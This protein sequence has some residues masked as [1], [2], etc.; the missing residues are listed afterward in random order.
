MIFLA[1]EHI[2][3]WYLPINEITPE[4]RNDYFHFLNPEEK[5][6]YAAFHFDKD[7]LRYLLTRVM[8]RHVLAGYLAIPARELT[9]TTNAF[10]RPAPIPAQNPTHIDINLSHSADFIICGLVGDGRI[11]VDIE[12]YAIQR[13]ADVANAFFAPV[14]V[15]Q[16]TKTSKSLWNKRFIEFWTLKESYIKALGKGMAIPL[17]SFYFQ[18]DSG[19]IEFVDLENTEDNASWC[20]LMLEAPNS[21]II[22][23]STSFKHQD[24]STPVLQIKPVELPGNPFIEH[25]YRFNLYGRS[26]PKIAAPVTV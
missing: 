15:A 8:V 7:R 12:S 24:N 25:A 21:N 14:E 20:F 13:T 2:D 10:G 26:A 18:L 16:L 19:Q 5:V 17:D 23:I 1:K 6:Q 22:S 3:L 4:Q 9:F 11:G